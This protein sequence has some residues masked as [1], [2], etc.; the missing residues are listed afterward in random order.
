MRKGL[1]WPRKHFPYY[2][3]AKRSMGWSRHVQLPKH[4]SR[5][6]HYK[7]THP[8][9]HSYRQARHLPHEGSPL[10][11]LQC[12][13]SPSY[14]SRERQP[15]KN[16]DIHLH[17]HPQTEPANHLNARTR[18][19]HNQRSPTQPQQQR[20]Y[21]RYRLRVIHFPAAT[22]T[23]RRVRKMRCKKDSRVSSPRM[24][25]RP[26]SQSQSFRRQRRLFEF[27]Y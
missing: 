2:R 18:R 19:K 1:S 10:T 3:I 24:K 6:V 25:S 14:T 9:G 17:P 21:L 13:L 26:Q 20:A 4:L 7:V 16:Q 12:T 27:G 22:L 8:N 15:P 11:L 23:G 5:Y